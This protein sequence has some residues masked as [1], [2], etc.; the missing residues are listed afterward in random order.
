M[1]R[2]PSRTPY[3]SRFPI[4]NVSTCPTWPGET[5]NSV[6]NPN[7]LSNPPAF[8]PTNAG[9]WYQWKFPF[10]S[11]VLGSFGNVTIPWLL[12]PQSRIAY[13]PSSVLSPTEGTNPSGSSAKPGFGTS[14]PG[15]FS[16]NSTPAKPSQSPSE[17][18]SNAG[19]T[20]NESSFA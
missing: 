15:A 14:T 6:L 13:H 16:S 8:E 10:Q 4:S 11:S 12:T 7:S 3:G 18:R 20:K 5:T 9:R 1:N 17:S 19:E 2:N